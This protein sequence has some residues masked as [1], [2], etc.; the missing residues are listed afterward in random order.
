MLLNGQRN[1]FLFYFCFTFFLVKIVCAVECEKKDNNVASTGRKKTFCT[2][3]FSFLSCEIATKIIIFYGKHDFLILFLNKIKKNENWNWLSEKTENFFLHEIE[4]RAHFWIL[5]M[6]CCS[7]FTN[8][9]YLMYM[10][11]H[12]Y[13]Y[14]NLLRT[15]FMRANT[16]KY[17]QK[18]VEPGCWV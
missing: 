16:Q 9:I 18:K 15:E 11:V 1:F 8:T 5:M 12:I 13:D 4:Y 2:F 6:L 10:H 3:F 14:E 7:A 17:E